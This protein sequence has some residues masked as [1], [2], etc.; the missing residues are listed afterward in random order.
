MCR[1]EIDT[2]Q[3]DQVLHRIASL[4][5]LPV[6]AISVIWNHSPYLFL[7]FRAAQIQHTGKTG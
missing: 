5:E 3:P 1:T 2:Y 4:A 7:G 6:Q